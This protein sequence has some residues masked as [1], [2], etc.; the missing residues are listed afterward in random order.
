MPT[1]DSIRI[2][3][4]IV[5]IA[6]LAMGIRRP[7]YAV[8]AYMIL[9]ICKVAS[10]YPAFAAMKGELVLA[11][12]I[13]CWLFVSSD[14]AT[15][16][17]LKYDRVNKYLFCFVL[18]VFLSYSIAWDHKYSWD[19]AVYHFIKVLFLYVMI[20][21]TLCTKQ[22]LKIFVWSFVMMFVYLAYEPFYGFMSGTGGSNQMYGTNYISEA[23][24]LSGHVALA[25]NMNQMI[26]IAFFLFLS[27]R[28]K[29]SKIL[30]IIPLLIFITALI[31]SGSRGGVVGFIVFCSLVVFFSENRLRN[32]VVV[33][34]AVVLLF[35]GTETFKSTASRID[36]SQTKGRLTG[37]THG[38]GI[39]RK[40]N[41]LGVGPGCF[42]FA[43]GKYFSFAMESH[44]IYGQVI[45]DLGVPGTAAWFFLIRQIFLNLISSKRRLKSLSREN[46]FLYKLAVGLQIS[47]IVRLFVSLGS[48]GLY[49]FYWYI[50]AALS[51]AISKLI[52]TMAENKPESVV[53]T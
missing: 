29:R 45:G 41:I 26:P 4:V 22:D 10:Y 25:N 53:V 42:L 12:L 39:L 14:F 38:I 16:L 8:I 5:P 36:E 28:E 24:I 33:A 9:V 3:T 19:N 6:L 30:A 18:C 32:A 7:V 43:R 44:N 27:V 49:Y 51:I 47:L 46:G 40:G 15:K 17:S 31:G 21:P 20:L 37:L 35:A 48:H 2:L 52:E 13:L 23:G 50:I 34:V 11:L 1:P